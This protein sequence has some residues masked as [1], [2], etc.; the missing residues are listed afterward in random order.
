MSCLGLLESV[1]TD[2][3]WRHESLGWGVL[4]WAGSRVDEALCVGNWF[5]ARVVLDAWWRGTSGNPGWG[6]DVESLVSDGFALLANFYLHVVDGR[7]RQ[8]RCRADALVRCVRIVF[9]KDI[10]SVKRPV[11]EVGPL[12]RRSHQRRNWGERVSM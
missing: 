7:V 2:C 10:G 11:S 5:W 12:L 1:V 8:S 4:D 3:L 6:S 9:W